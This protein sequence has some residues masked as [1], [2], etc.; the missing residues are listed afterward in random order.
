MNILS[1]EQK[2][3]TDISLLVGAV[4]LEYYGSAAD[5]VEETPI[6]LLSLSNVTRV[7]SSTVRLVFKLGVFFADAT[8]PDLKAQ[9]YAAA[10]SLIETYS[11]NSLANECKILGASLVLVNGLNISDLEGSV[12]DYEFSGGD[13]YN[14]VLACNIEVTVI[15]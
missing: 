4:N 5:T 1:I 6:G 13:R 8:I 9:V 10:S 14:Y 11:K 3:I 15:A 2:L 7:D 12:Q